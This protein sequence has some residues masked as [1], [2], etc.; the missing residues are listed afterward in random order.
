MPITLASLS[1]ALNHPFDTIIDVRSPDEYAED[2]LPGAINLPALSNAERA[3]VGTIYKQIS[4]FK[5]RK[6]GAAYVTQNISHHLKGPLAEHDG[7]WQPLVYCWRGGQ[8]SGS[9]TSILQQ[10]GWRADVVQGG[11]QSYR[12]LV[13]QAL[14][15]DPVPHRLILLDGYTGTAKTDLLYEL[16]ALGLQTIDLEG[17]ANHRG[18]LLGGMPGGQPSQ[19]GFESKLAAALTQLDPSKPTVLEAESSKIGQLSLPSRLWD[20]MKHAPRI[21]ITAPEDARSHYL[22]RTYFTDQT[23]YDDFRKCLQPLR[24]HRGHSVVEGWEALLADRNHVELVRALITQH[25]DPSYARSRKRMSHNVVGQCRAESLTPEAIEAL[26]REVAEKID[27][28]QP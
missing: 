18:S 16:R 6:I 25:Y 4:P 17:L 19:K 12:R 14:Y 20:A 1:E 8:R 11:Y 9:F 10:I 26:A 5:A 24:Q 7:S 28:Q 22:A 3:E 15:V 2:H 21:E 23:D 27:S 13:H